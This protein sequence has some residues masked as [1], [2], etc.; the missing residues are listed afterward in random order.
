MKMG[1][2]E[3][4]IRK[5][6]EKSIVYEISIMFP[7]DVRSM[8]SSLYEE[9]IKSTKKMNN[10]K[11]VIFTCVCISYAKLYPSIYDPFKIAQYMNIDRSDMNKSFKMSNE[12]Y[13]NYRKLLM[14]VDPMCVLK[15]RIN[16]FNIE[17]EDGA[18]D[19]CSL[20]L[21]RHKNNEYLLNSTS[22]LEIAAGLIAYYCYIN[23]ML[24]TNIHTEISKIFEVSEQMVRSRLELIKNIDN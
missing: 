1:E 5:P 2:Q 9:N 10:R 7:D 12:L 17:N 19:V 24:T 15:S 20:I 14:K 18:I 23:G 22:P 4:F 8:A 3:Y 13:K 6:E 11:S 16:E 21:D